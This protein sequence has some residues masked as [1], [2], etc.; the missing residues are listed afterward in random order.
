[1]PPLIRR[2]ARG[3]QEICL[4]G[5]GLA[6]AV[7][8]PAGAI[9]GGT[10]A[11]LKLSSSAHG[12][13]GDGRPMVEASAERHAHVLLRTRPLDAQSARAI[14]A[15]LRADGIPPGN[16][17]ESCPEMELAVEQWIEREEVSPTWYLPG[18]ACW[19]EQLAEMP[20]A[21]MASIPE[22]PSPTKRPLTAHTS[23][24][25]EAREPDAEPVT[26]STV[27]DDL[28]RFNAVLLVSL[29]PVS[30]VP[31]SSHTA[32]EV[33]GD[34]GT[35][36]HALLS[37]IAPNFRVGFLQ[38]VS[39][40]VMKESSQD[41]SM[42]ATAVHDAPAAQKLPPFT[43]HLLEEWTWKP[44][45]RDLKRVCPIEVAYGPTGSQRQHKDVDKDAAA[46]KMRAEFLEYSKQH[47]LKTQRNGDAVSDAVSTRVSW[48]SEGSCAS[49]PS[50]LAGSGDSNVA[51]EKPGTLTSGMRG[52]HAQ[53]MRG[54]TEE[55]VLQALDEGYH[56]LLGTFL[57]KCPLDFFEQVIPQ[58]IAHIVGLREGCSSRAAA[59]AAVSEG[60]EKVAM[61][62]DGGVLGVQG[63]S[64]QVERKDEAQ[65][66]EGT[67]VKEKDPP[68]VVMSHIIQHWIK[69]KKEWE[70]WQATVKAEEVKRRHELQALLRLYVPRL[71]GKAI[72]DPMEKTTLGN[73]LRYSTKDCA[74][75]WLARGALIL[76]GPVSSQCAPLRPLLPVPW[77][78]ARVCLHRP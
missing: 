4:E 23:S 20:G 45:E 19:C 39:D 40:E 22:T 60:E 8:A 64:A 74:L 33:S 25:P 9:G 68:R 24:E 51:I 1:M 47:I 46:Q 28:A 72:A 54:A 69:K 61:P 13:A 31:S 55:E 53:S 6:K 11:T 77:R 10:I 41:S 26:L 15:C 75:A 37:S 63:G 5:G 48:V 35:V 7:A 12:E 62:P 59:P 65:R 70:G 49:L 58:C 78:K 38:M 18:A 42:A 21:E 44:C 17:D 57:E 66:S 27:L 71:S 52:G 2:P 67:Q 76:T 29:R 50:A 56:G 43:S 30:K 14:R 73:V 3:N 34:K 16:G 36:Q 32:N